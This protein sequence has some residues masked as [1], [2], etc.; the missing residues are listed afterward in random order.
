MALAVRID[1]IVRRVAEIFHAS[2][3]PMRL[4]KGAATA[5][6]DHVDP[7]LRSYGDA[8]ILVPTR[9]YERAGQL[10]KRAGFE[11]RSPEFTRGFD[12]RFAKS[13]TFI[14]RDGF[15]LDLH[16]TIVYGPFSV[17]IPEADLWKPGPSFDIG[18]A[19]VEA[20]EVNRRFLHACVHTAV[21]SATPRFTSLRD[22]VVLGSGAIAPDEIASIATRWRIEPVVVRAAELVR[23]YFGHELDWVGELLPVPASDFRLRCSLD[24]RSPW[25]AATVGLL[26]TLPS[27]SDRA[28]LAR[29]LSASLRTPRERSLG[30]RACSFVSAGWRSAA[31][32]TVARPRRELSL[33]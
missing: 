4:L 13:V 30:S 8:D 21:G 33:R 17:G 3:V 31:G 10:L 25:A 14:T 20:L 6:L 1:D 5:H 27:W 16:R 26:V 12:S 22:V 24:E 28:A 18:G 15:E 2:S 29:M 7:S 9:H 11:R 23:S 32:S 19:S